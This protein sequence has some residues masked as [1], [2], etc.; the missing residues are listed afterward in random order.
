MRLSISRLSVLPRHQIV[1]LV[2]C[3]SVETSR[4]AHL[5]PWQEDS[6]WR[7]GMPGCS[8]GEEVEGYSAATHVEP[9]PRLSLASVE[10]RM[11]ED[12]KE[13]GGRRVRREGE[14]TRGGGKSLHHTPEPTTRLRQPRCRARDLQGVAGELQS[15]ARRRDWEEGR[16][17]QTARSQLADPRGGTRSAERRGSVGWRRRTSLPAL[18]SS[19]A[20]AATQRRRQA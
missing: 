17:T 8:G 14:K 3:S 15:W 20:R 9:G 18:A 16:W 13:E 12:E 2:S 4:A 19:L 1:L 5:G 6:C 11:R 7:E 10:R